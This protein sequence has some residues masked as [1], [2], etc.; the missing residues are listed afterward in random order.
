MVGGEE[1]DGLGALAGVA[2]FGREVPVVWQVSL[3]D[4]A[5]DVTVTAMNRQAWMDTLVSYWEGP[6]RI[7]GSHTGRGYLEMTGY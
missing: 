1:E 5:V 7:T 3:P 6:V 2:A 4:R